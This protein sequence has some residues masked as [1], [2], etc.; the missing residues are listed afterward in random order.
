VIVR[1]KERD[2]RQSSFGESMGTNRGEP[3]AVSSAER[4]KLVV[5]IPA[6][7]EEKTIGDVVA[8]VPRQLDG[9]TSVEVIVVDDGSDDRTMSV[10]YDAGADLVV[11][12]R[13]RRGL[14]SVFN[15]A[16]DAALAR[17]ADFAV[18]ID[19]DG[20]HDPTFIPAMIAP[21]L[22][23]AADMVIGVRPLA[24]AS[25]MSAARRHGNR[26]GT[27]VLRFAL[28][29]NVSDATSGFRGFTREALLRFNVVTDYTYTLETLIQ[30][31]RKGLAVAEVE[32]PTL[33]RR[34]GVSRMTS[35][36]VRYIWRSGFQAF[37]ALVHSDPLAFFGRLAG[38]CAAAAVAIG[39]WF[40]VGYA[41]GGLHL[42]RLL[43]T[44]AFL[45][46]S[47]T[48]FIYGLLADG[49]NANRRLLEDSLYRLKRMESP[50]AERST[51]DSLPARRAAAR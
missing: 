25:T 49:I 12:H 5:F 31:A 17:G 39:A 41:N 15:T 51:V 3:R 19:G 50:A 26:I 20:Q 18:Q 16:V 36:I 11:R 33:E 2:V 13:R 24:R 45:V 34:E 38:V 1:P 44:I 21:L 43:A 6:L 32:V 35:S 46:L 28:K 14:V 10:A 9:V 22:S 37:R 30:S 29:L 4:R 8:A 47:G 23:A 7:N 42:P 27:A 40:F 48:F